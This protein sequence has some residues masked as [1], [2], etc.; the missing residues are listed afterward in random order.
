MFV[1]F[2]NDNEMYELD[3]RDNGRLV[4]LSNPT[5]CVPENTSGFNL[6]DDDKVTVLASYPKHTIIYHKDRNSITFACELIN[7]Y[8]VFIYDPVTTYVRGCYIKRNGNVS[9][10]NNEVVFKEISELEYTPES[11]TLN[12]KDED[13]F[14][15]YKVI[16][17]KVT[18]TTED[19][20]RLWL[21]ERRSKNLINAISSKV[22][23]INTICNNAI[24]TGID[25]NGEHFSY[26]LE[27]QN[28]I[29]NLLNM[30][31]TSG[32]MDVPYHADG[33]DCRLYSSSD[34]FA[35]YIAQKTNLTHHTTY[36]NQL[37]RYVNTLKT[38]EEIESVTYGQELTGQYLETYNMMMSQAQAIVAAIATTI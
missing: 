11:I 10:D 27:D 34:V 36:A 8:I 17:G 30:T 25:Y 35:I 22:S 7:Y 9:I 33:A 19:D 21:L 15:I 37:K 6:I 14:Y 13:N 5:G 4:I 3:C 23:E 26:S 28:N 32:G 2:N 29:D 16:D 1:R 18:T 12:Y 20:K 24:T 38:I 31:K